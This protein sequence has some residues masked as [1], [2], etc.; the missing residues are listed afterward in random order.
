M[1]QPDS[2]SKEPRKEPFSEIRSAFDSFF[3]EK[4]VKGFLQS[5]D[6]LFSHS[7]FTERSFP[8]EIHEDSNDYTVSA[9]L[10]GIPR[11]QIHIEM[12]KQSLMITVVDTV[13]TE[14]R[15]DSKAL[16]HREKMS[17]AMSRTIAFTKPVNEKLITASHKDGVLIITVPKIRGKKISIS[18]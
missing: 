4:P 7:L 5:I 1:K 12:I 10:P 14:S 6:E 11:Q 18:E 16:V 3:Q 9:K 17:K 2:S 15:N 8:V 13:E